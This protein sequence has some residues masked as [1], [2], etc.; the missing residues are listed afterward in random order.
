YDYMGSEVAVATEKVVHIFGLINTMFSQ[1]N[2]TVMLS[3]LELW[4]DQNKISTN[5]DADEVLQR[6]LLWK[7]KFLFQRSHDMAYLLVYRD[8]PN[9]VGVTYHGM[10]CDPQ[11][12]AGIALYPKT[13]TLEAFSVVMVQ[14]LG[15][16]LGLTYDDIYNCYCLGTT[17][18]MNPEAIQSRGVKFFSS[19][20]IDGF[21]QIISQPELECLQNQPVSKVTY[22]GKNPLCGNRIVESNEQCDCGPPKECSHKKCCNPVDCTLIG[23]AE[24]G[25][26]TCCD[27]ST[28]K[29]AVRG[30][31][32]RKSQDLCDL[33]EYCNGTSEFCV[34]DVKTADLELCNNDTTYCYGGIC[35]D[36]DKQC[37]EL[38]GKF[39]KVSSY[40]CGQEI[41]FL[42]DKFGNCNRRCDF[43][44]ILCGKIVCHWAHSVLIPIINYD[45]QYTLMGG[46]VCVSAHLRNT[47][48]K[49][50]TYTND[51]TMC[52]KGKFC[53]QKECLAVEGHKNLTLCDSK[54]KC[55]GHGVCNDH[56]NCHCDVGYSPPTC[57]PAPS[58]PGGSMDDGYWVA[59]DRSPSL[60]VKH[61]AAPQKNGLLISFYI[62]LPFLILTAI[63]ALKWNK[64]KGIW[65]RVGTVS[66]ESP[67]EDSS[68]DSA[69]SYT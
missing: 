55:Q 1:L 22:Q 57:E 42:N 64:M 46:Q 24:C 12:A 43:R 3:S 68:C 38:F 49:D 7:R 14:L 37:V 31:L 17:C 5:G 50:I 48:K 54:V 6:F 23:F 69:Q 60:L 15:I 4:S 53:K 35:Q 8:H 39:A 19:C 52:G 51:G 18:I 34:P 66:S 59:T 28:C 40:L 11:F 33:P 2:V 21:K 56:F 62:F 44:H 10:A 16:N 61:Q 45:I 29:I 32:C 36:P 58:S 26:G 25:T 41:N 65:S 63:I 30:H 47:S 20:S 13:I 9:Y 27:T 67:S